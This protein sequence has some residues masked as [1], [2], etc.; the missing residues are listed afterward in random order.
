M[1]KIVPTS[2]G[3][4][5]MTAPDFMKEA[6]KGTELLK[7]YV[8]PPRLKVV[9]PTARKP[10]SDLFKQGDVVAVP[11]MQKVGSYDETDRG[12]LPLFAFVP[13]FFW[14]EWCLW[15]PLDTRGTLPAVRER[16]LD[17]KSVLAIKARDDKKRESEVCPE[18]PA[19]DGKKLYLSYREHLNY[20]IVP[21]APHVLADM[22][23]CMSFSKGEHR[24]G[25]NFSS[26]ITMRK[27]PLYGCQFEAFARERENAKGRWYGIDVDNP[28]EGS[29]V[30]PFIMEP[31]R[32]EAFKGIY[33]EFKKAYDERLLV[34]DF[35][36]EGEELEAPKDSK[37]F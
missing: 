31:E 9:Q 17:A 22:P 21:L 20:M 14:P 15:N 37:D 1:G 13:V 3:V 8:Q 10:F 30:T 5:A 16:S 34:V 32:F 7:Q 27:A 24:A 11:M 18:M 23:I 19:K 12:K 4:S 6:D 25:S 36:D 2:Q 33:E 26:I 28:R 29:G 35:E